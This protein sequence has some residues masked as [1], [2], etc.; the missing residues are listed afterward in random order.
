MESK[1][2]SRP[3]DDLTD[4]QIAKQQMLDT[5]TSAN[6]LLPTTALLD[7]QEDFRIVVGTYERLLYGV[8]A[9]WNEDVSIDYFIFNRVFFGI[10]KKGLS[11]VEN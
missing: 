3:E 8:N 1:K 9:F 5:F 4:A 7:V 2:R 10:K 11:H 6:S